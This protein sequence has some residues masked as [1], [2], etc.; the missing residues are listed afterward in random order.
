MDLPL[1]DDGRSREM[2]L[3]PMST[4]NHIDAARRKADSARAMVK[5]GV[6]PVD[7]RNAEKKVELA[8]LDKHRNF[9]DLLDEFLRRKIR[10]DIFK[11][12]KRENGGIIV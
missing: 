1:Y 2:G 11:R 4:V 12:R 9:G 8:E 10:P 7:K 3:G 6:D 5:S